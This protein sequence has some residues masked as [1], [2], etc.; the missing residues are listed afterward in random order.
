MTNAGRA[1]LGV[2]R[3][4]ERTLVVAARAGLLAGLVVLLAIPLVALWHA[5]IEPLYVHD[6][7]ADFTLTDQ[8]GHRWALSQQRGRAPVALFFGYTHC[9]DICP[10][11][12]AR[13]AKARHARAPDGRPAVIAF[14]T[15]DPARDSPAVL[16]RYVALFGP[17]IVGLSGTPAALAPVYR[18][19]HVWFQ[20]TPQ[21]EGAAGYVVA[22]ST[23]VTLIDVRGRLHGTADW[24]DSVAELSRKLQ[25]L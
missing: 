9:P 2:P 20:I 17:G 25:E 3:R 4:R 12:L 1:H 21:G 18:A 11:T 6:E 15:V 8:D 10:T 7:A 16:K 13:L 22:H 14:V 24:S 23:A 19:Y 5:F